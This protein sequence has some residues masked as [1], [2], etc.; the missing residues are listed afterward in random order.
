M[1][2]C[3]GKLQ[4]RRDLLACC[5]V[6][7]RQ[8]SKKRCRYALRQARFRST[9]LGVGATM[10]L[11]CASCARSCRAQAP[12]ANL[13]KL[14][15]VSYRQCFGQT[16]CI[17]GS[18]VLCLMARMKH[19]NAPNWRRNCLAGERLAGPQSTCISY[20]RRLAV[21]PQNQEPDYAG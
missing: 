18:V 13:H 9:L 5:A 2:R 7:A 15:E 6:C 10:D 3:W 4:A 14:L 8:T 11:T 20:L 12:T 19:C 16:S 21:L 1:S 17:T